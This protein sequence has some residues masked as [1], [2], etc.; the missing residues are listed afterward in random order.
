MQ[1]DFFE[2]ELA[3][4]PFDP[5][6]QEFIPGQL[7]VGSLTDGRSQVGVVAGQQDLQEVVIVQQFIPIQVEIFEELLEVGGL[8]FSVAVLA[9]ELGELSSIDVP[10]I[11]PVNSLE[12]S[13]GFE[14]AHGSQ[15]LAQS[16]NGNL[17]LCVI[18]QDLLHFQFTFVSKHFVLRFPFKVA[19]SI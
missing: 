16:F 2:D 5:H 3:E 6:G 14:V 10:C 12:G 18:D 15:N 13:V 7:I 19:L 1:S 4:C 17:L 8:Q 11:V 9:L